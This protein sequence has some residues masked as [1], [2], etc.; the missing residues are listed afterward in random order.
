M[1][2]LLLDTILALGAIIVVINGII[3]M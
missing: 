3:T 2:L 1:I